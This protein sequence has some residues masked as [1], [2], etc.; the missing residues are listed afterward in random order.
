M[1]LIQ[2][3]RGRL[4]FAAAFFG[5]IIFFFLAILINP[6]MVPETR[7]LR[8]LGTGFGRM[9]FLPFMTIA[10][11]ALLWRAVW[12]FVVD[13]VAVQFTDNYLRLGAFWGRRDIR[14]ED[15]SHASIAWCQKHAQLR[16]ETLTGKTTK[17]PLGGTDLDPSRAQELVEAVYQKAG[18]RF[19][20][21]SKSA[22]SFDADAAIERHLSQRAADAV[23]AS[24]AAGG[25]PGGH[26]RPAFGRK[27]V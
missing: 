13:P 2:Y 7:R 12:T 6:E 11:F 17:V 4:V 20:S 15:I 22:L 23:V 26:Q 9:I 21:S 8:W 18:R 24:A 5:G 3:D 27:G 14:W 16:I 1:Q 10:C 19:A 25:S